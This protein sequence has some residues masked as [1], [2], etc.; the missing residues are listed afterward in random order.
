MTRQER[1]RF[2]GLASEKGRPGRKQLQRL[3]CVSKLELWRE[4]NREGG[5]EGGRE[6][7]MEG[8]KEGGRKAYREK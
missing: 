3:V 5:I 7:G 2:T 1:T 8:E 6:K 4:G